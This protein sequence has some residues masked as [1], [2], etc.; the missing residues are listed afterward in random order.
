MLSLPLAAALAFSPLLPAELRPP[1]F[2]CATNSPLIASPSTSHRHRHSL[3]LLAESAKPSALAGSDRARRADVVLRARLF[4]ICICVFMQFLGVGVT[5][6]TLPLYLI[7]MGASTLQLSLVVSAFSGAQML[8]VPFLVS[9]SDR[10]GRS[11]VV[12]LCMFGAAVAN[13]LTAIAPGYYGAAGA[14]VLAGLFAAANPVAQAAVADIVPPGPQMTKALGLIAATC[15]MGITVGPALAAGVAG[16]LSR[17][18]ITGISLQSRYVFGC[19]AMLSAIALLIGLASG[20]GEPTSRKA[21]ATT[22]SQQVEQG[23]SKQS[24]RKDDS[25]IVAPP[26]IPL[27]VRLLLG[28]SFVV[29]CAV[30]LSVAT[31]TPFAARS[32]GFGQARAYPLSLFGPRF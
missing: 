11:P 27:N 10:L 17:C 24:G 28:L 20:L 18:G 19:S 1:A 23:D 7:E 29:G 2:L 32:L 13:L 6:S 26:R 3:P 31:Y 22:R 25:S 15:S 12:L 9:L 5:L 14:R 4:P 21:S 16:L 8:G 30:T